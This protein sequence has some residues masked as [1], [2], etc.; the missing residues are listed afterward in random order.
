VK[1]EV[2]LGM[3]LVARHRSGRL[4]AVFAVT[5]LALGLLDP[6]SGV[7]RSLHVLLLIGGSLGAVA[8]SRLLAPG[9]ALLAA[10]RVAARWWVAPAG[11][12][13]GALVLVAPLLALGAAIQKP[14]GGMVAVVRL[15]AIALVQAAALVGLV[16]GLAPLTGATTAGTLG[17]VAAWLGGVP[18]SGIGELL[19]SWTY[20]RRVAVLLWNVLPL[21]WRAARWAAGGPVRDPALLIGWIVAGV[22]LGAWAAA[23]A[24]GKSAAPGRGV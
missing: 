1:A 2:V 16:A 20:A 23:R 21:G 5:L 8:G 19:G 15:A 12:L 9:P 18:P 4:V 11:R 10:R 24:W 14:P 13:L 3:L 6:G 17:L 7:T 22:G